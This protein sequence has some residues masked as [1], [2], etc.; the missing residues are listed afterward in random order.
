MGPM[1]ADTEFMLLALE[2]AK[3]ALESAEVP[4]GCV[5]VN[6]GKVIGEGHNFTNNSKNGTRHAELCAIDKIL[7]KFSFDIFTSTDLYVT[8]EPCIMCASALRQ[9]GIKRVFFGAGNER[10]GGCGSVIAINRDTAAQSIGSSY[11]VIPNLKRKEAV[12]LLRQF[13]TN[14][15]PTA[16]QPK[17]KK[18]R[19]IKDDIPP[20]NF[21]LYM[22]EKQFCSY[23]GEENVEEFRC[24]S[25]TL[26]I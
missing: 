14:L 20:I 5:F 26:Q 7:T 13:Y 24:G 10:F 25:S 17:A 9:V 8:V 23:Y 19:I 12:L 2:Q 16:P 11:D 1:E 21:G 3:K 22:T 18:Q 6:N 4:V 15:N